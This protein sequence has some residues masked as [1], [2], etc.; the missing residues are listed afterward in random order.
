MPA[1]FLL[2]RALGQRRF[3]AQI[4]TK[5]G[6]CAHKR[7][8]VGKSGKLQEYDWTEGSVLDDAALRAVLDYD[9]ERILKG[10]P[11]KGIFHED[12]RVDVELLMRHLPAPALAKAL[13]EREMALQEAAC[14]LLDEE[15]LGEA[16]N[17]LNTYMPQSVHGETDRE[18]L[19]QASFVANN[20]V[21]GIHVP[22]PATIA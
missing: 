21:G 3:L 17:L 15:S 18:D 2:C 7:W 14:L 6:M 8:L 9:G 20:A 4:M 5:R 19:S 11:V 12:R 1:P 13:R 16:V 22:T 10:K